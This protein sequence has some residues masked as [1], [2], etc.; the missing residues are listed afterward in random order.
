MVDVP[1]EMYA[2]ALTPGRVRKGDLREMVRRL[3]R[4]Y[5]TTLDIG[6]L[7]DACPDLLRRPR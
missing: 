3:F 6:R 5:P 1:A 4:H 7:A 2:L